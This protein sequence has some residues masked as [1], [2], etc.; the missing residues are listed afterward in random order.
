MQWKHE[1]NMDHVWMAMMCVSLICCLTLL[2][3]VVLDRPLTVSA[4]QHMPVLRVAEP[5]QEDAAPTGLPEE[6]A[7]EETLLPAPGYLLTAESM[8]AI[9]LE[10]LPEPLSAAECVEVTLEDG[11]LELALALRRQEL[12]SYL[13]QQGA[14]FSLGQSLALRMLPSRL[15]TAV[16]FTVAADETGLHLTP[17]SLKAGEKSLSLSQ[18]PEDVFAPV[19]QA[20]N[21]ALEQQGLH[22]TALQ[23]TEEGLLL[24]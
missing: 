1:W 24:E 10:T 23:W 2:G 12:I 18:L 21:Q 13:K 7:T 17:I 22:F 16:C 3:S 5:L 9:L 8:E 4:E 20:L 15:E 19:D 11:M 14:S 6:E